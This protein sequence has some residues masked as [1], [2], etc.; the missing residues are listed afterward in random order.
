MAGAGPTAGRRAGGE[1]PGRTRAHPSGQGAPLACATCC[2]HRFALPKP[3][4]TRLLAAA[5][6][7]GAGLVGRGM[8]GPLP[9][10]CSAPGRQL[11]SRA[12]ADQRQ[13]RG[14]RARTRQPCSGPCSRPLDTAGG[15]RALL[16]AALLGVALRGAAGECRRRR[17]RGRAD[18][19]ARPPQGLQYPGLP[20]VTRYYNRCACA[21]LHSRQPYRPMS[22]LPCSRRALVV[23]LQLRGPEAALHVPLHLG[24]WRPGV[25][26][27]AAGE[28]PA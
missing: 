24:A 22:S 15:M 21:P 16:I 5:R 23:Q 28:Q 8:R 2:S 10:S 13:G 9:C 25:E 18:G 6:P 4:A 11:Q 7:A 3:H 26:G 14:Q 17:W 27:G 1:R 20:P 12:L 19:L